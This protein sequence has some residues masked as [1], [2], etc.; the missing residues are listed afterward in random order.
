MK[1][2]NKGFA[3]TAV[4]YGLL[5]LFV[6]LVGSYLLVLSAKK[7]RVE[8]VVNDIEE[9]YKQPEE[10][11]QSLVE[12]IK[13]LYNESE[14][15]QK[16]NNGI[17]Y[18]YAP[19]YDTDSDNNTSGGI[20]NDRHDSSGNL[21]DD[22]NG[23]NIRY[24]GTN[25]NNYI[26]FNCDDY[27]NQ[28]SDTC[29]L[30]RII[31]V[32]KDIK[33]TDG[34]TK[35]L[36]KIVHS[37][38]STD[39]KWNENTEANRNNWHNAT[40]QTLLNTTY[41]NGTDIHEL[42]GITRKTQSKIENVIWNLGND[43]SVGK[44]PNVAYTGERSDV[45]YSGNQVTWPGKIALPYPSD[46]GYATDFS[47]CNSQLDNYSSDTNCTKK[48]WLFKKDYKQW[49]LTPAKSSG[50]TASYILANGSVT[51]NFTGAVYSSYKVFR[52]ILFLNP[53]EVLVS[54]SGTSDDPYRIM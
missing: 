26:Y 10:Y 11:K 14:K 32:F 46:Y 16:E 7:D 52:P 44:F 9:E 20:M 3:I 18:N 43:N 2:N 22:L 36:I 17:K 53:D 29:E 37:N 1:L 13:S 41:Y 54:G 48:D 12:Y 4:L 34:S 23:G 49:L 27:S 19:I 31:G 50:N 25:P 47:L 5:I 28:S 39:V 33:L 51:D 8:D 40:L 38:V 30:W 45:V 15:T 21:L 42:K 24:Y 6:F 35:D